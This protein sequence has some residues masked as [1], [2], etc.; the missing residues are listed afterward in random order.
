MPTTPQGIWF[1]G[2]SDPITPIENVFATLAESADDV[3]GVRL[4]ATTQA[5]DDAYAAKPFML[6][7]V[8]ADFDGATL[9]KRRSGNWYEVKD[10]G[11]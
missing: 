10:A 9:Y 5:R 11:Q 7:A 2:P 1:P 4:F 3:M 8:G 6:A